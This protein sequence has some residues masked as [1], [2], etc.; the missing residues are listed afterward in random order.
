[1]NYQ[2]K[3]FVINYSNFGQTYIEKFTFN[4][5]KNSVKNNTSFQIEKLTEKEIVSIFF[6]LNE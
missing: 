3:T 2:N 5:V 6:E 1:M 4:E